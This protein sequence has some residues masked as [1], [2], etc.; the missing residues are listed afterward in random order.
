MTISRHVFRPAFFQERRQVAEI[1]QGSPVVGTK[2]KTGSG[3]FGSGRTAFGRERLP[4]ASTE[5][6]MRIDTLGWA[7]IVGVVGDVKGHGFA[8]GADRFKAYIPLASKSNLGAWTLAARTTGD[9]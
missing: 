5:Q 1:V 3:V 9:P 2:L 4:A 8:T 7:T 6:R